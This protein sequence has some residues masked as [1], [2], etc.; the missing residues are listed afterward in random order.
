MTVYHIVAINPDSVTHRITEDVVYAEQCQYE[1]MNKGYATH[2]Y[3]DINS[4]VY[5]VVYVHPYYK[6][7]KE[8]KK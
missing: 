8:L 4:N 3:G 6:E 1:Y 5:M 7:L 2:D